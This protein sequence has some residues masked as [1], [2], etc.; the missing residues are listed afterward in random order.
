[1]RPTLRLAAALGVLAVA[2]SSGSNDNAGTAS[3]ARAGISPSAPVASQAADLRTHLDLLL[4]EQV[5]IVAKETAAAAGHEDSYGGYTALLTS[6]QTDLGAII[7]TA[8]GDTAADNFAGAWATQNASLVDYGIGVVTHNDAKASSAMSSLNGAVVQQLAQRITDMSGLPADMITQL[9]TQQIA[10]DKAFIDDAGAQK[11]SAFYTDVQTSYFAST[12]LGDAL[13]ARIAEKFSD[14]FPGDPT[15]PA[16]DRRVSLNLLFQEHAFLATLASDA[17]VAGRDTDKS[18]ATQAMYANA[19]A[20][21]R[22]SSELFGATR[23]SAFDKAWAAR[24]SALLTYAQKG[25]AVSKQALTATGPQLASA[26]GIT[27]PPVTVE[28]AALV[29]VIDD[30]R[31][32]ESTA[33]AGDDRA[34]ATSMQPVADA[35]LAGASV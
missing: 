22:A 20:L 9:L 23:G 6:N 30:Q 17:V 24:M 2:C 7:R 35:V 31:M 8:Y 3:S 26:I 27:A 18:A 10:D 1:M 11:Y 5:M 34:A 19:A 13:A 4:A 14:R 29:K 12:R 15:V 25:D 16:V 32:K 33:I 21:S 28:L